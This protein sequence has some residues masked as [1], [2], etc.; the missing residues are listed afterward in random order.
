MSSFWRISTMDGGRMGPRDHGLDWTVILI[1][2]VA[3]LREWAVVYWNVRPLPL[4]DTVINSV[5]VWILKPTL[6]FEENFSS[7]SEYELRWCIQCAYSHTSGRW[8]LPDPH[9]TCLLPSSLTQCLW[10]P[11]GTWGYFWSFFRGPTFPFPLKAQLQSSPVNVWIPISAVAWSLPWDFARA[12]IW[13]C[14]VSVM[15][16]FALS[17][18]RI[19]L[20]CSFLN[21]RW[22]DAWCF[23]STEHRSI[24]ITLRARLVFPSVSACD[25]MG[26]HA[27][28]RVKYIGRSVLPAVFISILLQ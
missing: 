4:T 9:T 26:C 11:S 21:L 19:K 2:A 7:A 22:H 17:C 27:L 16:A 12:V 25:L 10:T 8:T 1:P 6:D 18:V 14:S 3:I 5:N 24:P 15:L 13:T 20:W 28:F 23:A